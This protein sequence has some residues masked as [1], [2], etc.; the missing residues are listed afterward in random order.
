M[1]VIDL[2]QLPTTSDE[3]L[4][5]YEITDL[6]EKQQQ[7]VHLYLSGQHQ[8]AKIAQLIELHPNTLWGWLKR[9]DVRTVIDNSQREIHDAVKDQIA[10]GALKGIRRMLELSDSPIDGVAVQANKDILDRAG[11]KPRQEI[12]V[13]KTV[14]TFEKQLMNLIDESIDVDY[15]EVKKEE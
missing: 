1:E 8:V 14:T 10:N 13:D 9:S 4:N 3:Q 5:T 7:F 15:E 11:F 12:K 6:T 2:K